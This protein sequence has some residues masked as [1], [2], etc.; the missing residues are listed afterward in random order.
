[1][2]V[3]QL[4]QY[5]CLHLKLKLKVCT[6]VTH[7]LCDFKLTVSLSKIV[8]VDYMYIDMKLTASIIKSDILI[9]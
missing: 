9:F 7:A 5:F 2:T 8:H 6:S 1:M 4:M 3:K